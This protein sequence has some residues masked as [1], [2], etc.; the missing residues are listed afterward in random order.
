MSRPIK[1]RRV[2]HFP[3][4]LE[5]SPAGYANDLKPVV[6]AIDEFETIRLIDKEG[7]SQEECAS[8]LEVGRTTVQRIYE[9]ARKKLANA[10]VLGLPL[11]IEGGDFSLCNGKSDLG[12]KKEC[13]SRK[14]Q[15]DMITK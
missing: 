4:I 6:L 15:T 9:T 11:K 13:K 2:C 14:A 12:Y 3:E 5:F 1:R 8:Q 7:L 10:L